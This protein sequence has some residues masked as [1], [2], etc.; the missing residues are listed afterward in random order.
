MKY[1]FRDIEYFTEVAERGNVGRAAEALGLSQPALSKSLRLLETSLQ[2]KLV[3][4][5]S[6]GVELTAAGREL[7]AHAHRLRLS[8][9]DIT[10]SVMDISQGR[11][12]HLRIGSGTGFALYVI[13][14]ACADVVTNAP[15]ATFKV[16]PMARNA[17]EAA[18]LNGEID[19]S[20]MTLL[21]SAHKD[22]VTE[23]LYDEV[24][25]IC[26]SANHPLAR[27]KRL[28][29]TDLVNEKWIVSTEWASAPRQLKQA[30]ADAG[31]PAPRIT[32]QS[33][34]QTL[35]NTLLA[36]TRLL[37]IANTRIVRHAAQQSA[38]VILP[39]SGF[40][41]SRSFGIYRRK[42]AYLPPIAQRFIVML[43]NAA[44]ETTDDGR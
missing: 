31:L 32:A 43:K 16:S 7:F 37:S 25:A 26:A 42:D 10:R 40:K 19:L 15:G 18:L 33:E 2:S 13:A 17:A 14:A 4:R 11:S 29:L 44:R 24:F 38:L 36:S 39:V 8:L 1:R 21:A 5:V 6:R 27:K 30:F 12:G 41:Y 34:S 28:A 9:D 20:V 23:H 35:R 3:K 22:L